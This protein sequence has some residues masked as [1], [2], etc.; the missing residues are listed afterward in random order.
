M[1]NSKIFVKGDKI[2]SIAPIFGD[3]NI[4]GK[5]A[6]VTDINYDTGLAAYK[7]DD[8]NSDGIMSIN[9][10]NKYFEKCEKKKSPIFSVNEERINWILENSEIESYTVFNKCTVVSCKL[11]N[12]FVI[13]ESSACV[14]PDNYNEDRG[15]N[16]CLD[17]IVDKI[18][19]LEGYLLQNTIFEDFKE[20]NC[21]DCDCEFN[22]NNHRNDDKK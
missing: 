15:I 1:K 8:F 7:F 12:G 16:I 3:T 14:D 2:K 11:P 6:T 18:W 22:P 13:T 4:V 17:K 10:L 21:E 19:E 20:P 9:V 5:I